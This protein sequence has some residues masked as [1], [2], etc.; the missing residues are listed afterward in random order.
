L[1]YNSDL[2]NEQLN[3]LVK[4]FSNEDLS[5]LK[6]TIKKVYIKG[7][8]KP[9]SN[10]SLGNQIITYMQGTEDART[11]NQWNKTGRLIKKGTKAIYILG[12]INKKIQSKIKG[13]NDYEEIYILS[14]FKSIPVF[15]IE[16]TYGP[17]LKKYIPDKPLELKDVADK[18]NLKIV[19]DSSNHG[20]YGSFSLHD[21]KIRLCTE[22]QTT[23]FHELAHKAHSKLE[24]LK[25]GQDPEQE[26]IA[27]L[28]ACTLGSMFGFDVKGYTYNYI[29]SYVG[30]KDPQVVGKMCLRVLSKVKK[31]LDMILKESED[32]KTDKIIEVKT[33]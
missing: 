15:K 7:M 19:Y 3:N 9:M 14:G 27:Q 1:S 33:K 20:E 23:F 10:W 25:A 21:D 16:D 29:A 31:I 5:N 26:A 8:D 2:V 22:D 28:V 11:F 6:D 13:T 12:P 30:S 18:W 24:K 4:L 32:I 17:A